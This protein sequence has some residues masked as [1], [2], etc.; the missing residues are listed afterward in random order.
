MCLFAVQTGG[1]SIDQAHGLL[2]DLSCR[3]A[4]LE[5]RLAQASPSAQSASMKHGFATPTGPFPSPDP[6]NLLKS[7][8]AESPASNQE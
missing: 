8:Y 4:S 6:K 7:L 2:D 1:E 5:T 3:V